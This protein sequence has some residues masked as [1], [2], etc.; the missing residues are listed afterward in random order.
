M[1]PG[2]PLPPDRRRRRACSPARALL[3]LL[4]AT[5]A[6]NASAE[7]HPL[8]NLVTGS[9][10]IAAAV[11]ITLADDTTVQ[12]ADAIGGAWARQ[13]LLAA[14]GDICA[15]LDLSDVSDRLWSRAL[16]AAEQRGDVAAIMLL[17]TL[18]AQSSLA[19]GD[20]QRSRELAGR[21]LVLARRHGDV[22][23]QA[24]AENALGVLERRRGRLDDAVA[25]QQRSLDLFKSTGNG[26]GAMRALS[27]LGTIWRDRGDFARALDAQLQ[28]VA[29]RGRS[30]DR[31]S[32]VY[33]NLALLYREIEDTAA[34]RAYFD[35]AIEAA[36]HSGVPSM[37]SSAT[38]AYASLLNDIEDHAGARKA[39]G[40]ALAIDTALGDLPHQGFE[41]LELGR[42]LLGEKQ[43][44]AAIG[45]LDRALEI[46]R[47]LGQRELVARALLHQTEIALAQR[48]YL[49][50]RGLIDEAVAGLE[51]TRLR[52]QLAQAYALREQL[53]RAEHDDAEALRY[54]HKSAAAR[55]E[56]I[57][58]RASR[59]LSA[60][61]VRHARSDADQR[62]A[63][64]GKDNELQAARLQA[65]AVQRRFGAIALAGLALA[66]L[67]LVWRYRGVRR[68][69]RALE[70]RNVEIERQRAALGE[71]N[72]QLERQ[73]AE[74]Y[75]AATTDWL[76]GVSNRRDA[77]ERI[78]RALREARAAGEEFAVLLVDFDHFKQIND[79]RG[80][81]LGDRALTVGAH[82]MRDCLGEG[83]VLGRFGGE[84]FIAAMRARAPADVMAAGERM[85]A[86]VAGQL[87]WLMPELRAIATVSIGIAFLSDTGG[88]AD[89]AALLEA[90]DRALYAAKH[91]G[92]NRVHRYAA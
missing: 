91:D 9:R 90:A 16:P 74:L 55:E 46:G 62:L 36:I 70:L 11:D 92:R 15:A 75:Q 52:S 87:A 6:A 63:M 58:I 69:N 23:A 64:L 60:L 89:V 65:Q 51:A 88:D 7:E 1:H 2:N 29:E 4:C 53:A 32:N 86:H 18:V 49:R 3:A 71:A 83:D 25:H 21:L 10:Q 45:H 30:G 61:E 85:R 43:T 76:T 33:R 20:Y 35:R 82:A 66:L 12:V 13:H 41:H 26:I 79:L 81:L 80:H 48:E 67:A 84:E 34:S 42:A 22:S 5:S 59:Q 78:E 68:L 54:A 77:L 73:A 50:A 47:T 72:T 37:Y 27:D 31:L 14:A 44:A 17:T 39:A 40:E 57:G 56:L 28:A 38:G 8:A 24:Q 19:L